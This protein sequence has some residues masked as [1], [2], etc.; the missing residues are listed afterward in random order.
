M[1]KSTAQ[2]IWQKPFTWFMRHNWHKHPLVIPVVMLLVLFFVSLGLFITSN[3]ERV[4]ASDSHLV[5][6]S[7]DK[8]QETLPTRAKTVDEFLKRVDVKLNEGDVVEPSLDTKILDEKFRINIYRARPVTVID[9]GKKTFAFSAAT[10]PRSVA[11]QAGLQ[12]YPEDKIESQMETNFLR[13]GAIGEKVVIDRAV[14]T[15]LN[16]YGTQVP[17][18]THAETVGDLLKEKKVELAKDDTVQPAL[19]T[20][21]TPQTQ[22]FVVRNGSQVVT[23]EEA[24]RMETQVIEDPTLS[25]GTTA[26]RQKGSPGKRLVTYQLDL[27]NGKEKARKVIQSVVAQEPVKQIVARGKTVYIPADKEAV[28]A[29]AGIA[30]SDYAYVNYIVSRES[31]WNAAARNSSS[32]AYGLCQALP[33]SKMATAGSDWATNP[34]T[35]LRWCD[36]YAKG[37]YGSWGAAYNYWLSH[38]YW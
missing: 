27:Q 15:N 32:G 29:A 3:G 12:V 22:I 20:P 38:H 30:R 25:F 6:F 8:K 10:T 36:G 5:I 13:D 24:I 9:N 1:T 7:H 19:N 31:G 33:G 28:M 17:V 34:V 11:S 26:I 16:L 2:P 18:R 35:Q 21:I 14:P 4:A 37:R 23:V